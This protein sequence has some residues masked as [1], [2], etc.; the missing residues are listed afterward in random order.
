MN[1]FDS[2]VNSYLAQIFMFLFFKLSQF[3]SLLENQDINMI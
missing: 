3:K 2:L 1:L